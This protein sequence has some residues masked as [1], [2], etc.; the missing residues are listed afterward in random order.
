M[1]C[2]VEALDGRADVDATGCVD[3]SVDI[4]GGEMEAGALNGACDDRFALASS[5][6]FSL[7]GGRGGGGP[8]GLDGGFLCGGG[9]GGGSPRRCRTLLVAAL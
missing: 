3:W 1:R 9:G 6:R 2:E 7:R 8:G 4:A 5:R